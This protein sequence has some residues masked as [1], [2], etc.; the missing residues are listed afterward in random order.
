M[1]RFANIF[2]ILFLVSAIAC[3][4]LR[5]T[6][7]PESPAPGEPVTIGINSGAKEAILYVN[8]K[9]VSK[10]PFFFIAGERK[11]PGFLVSTIT[12]PSTVAPQEAV[13]QLSDARGIVHEIP[14]TIAERTFPSQTI[15]LNPVNTD[16]RTA[17]NPQREAEANHLWRI[18]TT[19]GE[20]F[21]HYGQFW[22]PVESTRRTSAFG[23]RRIYKY[24]NGGTDTS[25]HAGI[26]YGVPTGTPVKACGRG[27]VVIAANRVVS[28]YTVVLEHAPGIY[29]SY[30]HMDS[31]NVE[32]GEIVDAGAL[33]GLSGSTGLSTGPHLHWEIRVNAENTDPDSFVSRQIIDK[34]LIIKALFSKEE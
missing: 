12:I 34:E 10:A 20:T 1:K 6:L 2:I 17:P 23:H 33:L 28:G 16:I 9:Q 25:I 13:I 3:A 21:Y 14:F 30:Y 7:I 15:E 32:E 26:D 19:T 4:Q 11:S 24:S 5:Y 22:P 29:S 31:L 18:L 27:R 8:G